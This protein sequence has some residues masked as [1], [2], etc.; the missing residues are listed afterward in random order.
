MYCRQGLR[1]C[2]VV[3]MEG[4]TG[5]RR[6]PKL[7][8]RADCTALFTPGSSKVRHIGS[9]CPTTVVNKSF[10]MTAPAWSTYLGRAL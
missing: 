10:I 6:L 7:A 5:P 1:I 4:R 8:F 3:R 2:W 9:M